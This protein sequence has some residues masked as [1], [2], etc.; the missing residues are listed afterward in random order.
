MTTEGHAQ[1]NAVVEPTKFRV[2][3][4]V[5]T[6]AESRTIYDVE[7]RMVNGVLLFA[8]PDG[9]TVAFNQT[10]IISV[11]R[12]LIPIKDKDRARALKFPTV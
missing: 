4:V 6:V 7:P 9:Q 11:E 12:L 5:K 3:H 8:G 1:N 2:C 10:H